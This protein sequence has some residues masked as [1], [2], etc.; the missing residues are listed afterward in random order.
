MRKTTVRIILSAISILYTE[1]YAREKYEGF[2]AVINPINLN[3]QN[4]FAINGSYQSFSPFDLGASV[5]WAGDINGDGIKD[6]LIG[7][8]VINSFAGQ[9]YVVFGSKR[10]WP[11]STSVLNLN[12]ANGFTING[13]N[14]NDNSGTV[15][16]A[17]D[18]NNDGIDDIL[19]GAPYASN[20]AGQCYIVFGSKS[21]WSAT[22]NLAD[23]N[24]G[25]GFV[26]N[27]INANDNSGY[28]VSGISDVNAD[29]IDDILIGAWG[30]NNSTGQSYVLFGSKN[31]WPQTINLSD[32]DGTNGVTINGINGNDY[33]G[34]SVSGAGDVNADGIADFLIGAFAANAAAGQSYLIFGSKNAW[35]ATINLSDLDGNI[36]FVINGINEH[37][38]SG[39][40]VSRA[41][42][43]NADGVDDI[44]IGAPGANNQAGQSYILFGSRNSW[45]SAINLSSLNGNNGFIINGVNANDSS[46]SAVSEAGDVNADGIADF[47]IGAPGQTFPNQAQ[48]NSYVIFGSNA[49]WAANFYLYTL[50]GNNGFAINGINSIDNCG[51]SVSGLEDVNGDGIDDVIIGSPN[52]INYIGQGYVIFGQR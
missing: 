50:N 33:S 22:I 46:G 15:S 41:G 2:P 30:V 14:A 40:S 10:L 37:D 20:K 31:P 38:G 16:G 25:N 13:I 44:L 8:E 26:I 48:G 12:G 27:G 47:L 24:G 45:P 36:G 42:D 18:V 34:W 11:N 4:G 6:I 21:P 32:L 29:G 9:T 51:F 1:G 39:S 52:A 43:V 7:D 5:S 19:I 17:G 28:A 3:G 23:L 35:P 49:S